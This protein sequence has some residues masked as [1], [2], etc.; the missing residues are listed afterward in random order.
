MES[1]E[2]DLR[3]EV[4]D[5]KKV[6]AIQDDYTKANLEPATARLLEFAVKLT[7]DP[8]GMRAKDIERVREA[9]FTDADVVDAVQLTAYFN[10]VNRVLDG[11][12]AE[13]EPEIRF[14]HAHP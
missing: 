7:L 4:H 2:P 8:K 12:G 14:R 10:Y 6:R 1:H 11:L 13:P 9:G 5:D 3:A